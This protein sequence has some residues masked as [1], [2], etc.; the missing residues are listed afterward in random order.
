MRFCVC[1]IISDP[2]LL[3]Q[4]LHQRSAPPLRGYCGSARWRINTPKR[5]SD[6]DE[7]PQSLWG[8]SW[9]GRQTFESNFIYID[10]HIQIIPTWQNTD[11]NFRKKIF[12][13]EEKSF[14]AKSQTQVPIS[15][16]DAILVAFIGFLF[17]N[18]SNFVMRK[19]LNKIRKTKQRGNSKMLSEFL[20]KN[21]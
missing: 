20:T 4:R 15:A 5:C 17:L 19:Y 13:L 6:S 14:R 7:E 16:Q 21:Q 8:D 18:K 12:E 2:P 1:F 3:Q 9:W 11:S 10:S